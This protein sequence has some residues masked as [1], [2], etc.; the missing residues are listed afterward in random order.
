MRTFSCVSKCIRR[1]S[2]NK[3]TPL[4][5][6]KMYRCIRLK[7]SIWTVEFQLLKQKT[8][9]C[10]SKPQ[11]FVYWADHL[12]VADSGRKFDIVLTLTGIT[13]FFTLATIYSCSWCWTEAS[14][15]VEKWRQQFETNCTM[16][17]VVQIEYPSEKCQFH[18]SDFRIFCS[19]ENSIENIE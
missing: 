7:W 3:W 11:Q 8:K 10:K 6:G 12:V 16:T 14:E 4:W 19:F 5:V 1:C 13:S 18:F 9:V 15:I 17:Y 2:P